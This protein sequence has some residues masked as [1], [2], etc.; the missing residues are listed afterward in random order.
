MI[1]DSQAEANI[2]L[3]LKIGQKSLDAFDVCMKRYDKVSEIYEKSWFKGRHYSRIS[4]I[5][6]RCLE[7]AKKANAITRTVLQYFSIGGPFKCS[8]VANVL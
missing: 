5:K 1:D 7:K 8:V 2:E 4:K 3:A 6:K